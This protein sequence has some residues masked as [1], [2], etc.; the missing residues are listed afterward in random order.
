VLAESENF[1]AFVVDDLRWHPRCTSGF[2]MRIKSLLVTLGILGSSSLAL[3]DH[4]GFDGR[5]DRRYREARFE[6]RYQPRTTWLALTSIETL[7]GR[8]DAFHIDAR[9]RFTQLRLQNQTGRSF[10]RA[11]LVELGN[12][13]RQR[14][15]VNR[16]LSGNHDMVN[17]QLPGG[18]RRI[19][20][21]V[22]LGDSRRN[23][24]YQLYAM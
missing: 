24:T 20:R 8:G 16:V 2:A 1:D 23:G 3:A 13:E 10:V 14:I 17:I 15:E 4:R 9:E 21:I 5:W 7:E 22:V 18:A 6:Q 12:G 19:E 11:I